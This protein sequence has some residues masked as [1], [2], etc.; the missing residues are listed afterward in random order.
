M[1]FA[2]SYKL[3]VKSSFFLRFTKFVLVGNFFFSIL[4]LF[5]NLFRWGELSSHF[6]VQYFG[7]AVFCLFGFC[8][9]QKWRWVIIAALCVA[10]NAFIIFPRFSLIAHAQT[11]KPDMRLV[12]SNVYH[13]NK[14][15]DGFLKLVGEENPDVLITQESSAGWRSALEALNNMYPYRTSALQADKDWILLFSKFPILENPENQK[16]NNFPPILATLQYKNQNFTLLSLH[17]STPKSGKGLSSRNLQFDT[18]AA[19]A[20]NISTPKIII[21]DF[22]SSTWSPYFSKLEKDTGLTSVRK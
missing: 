2:H 7:I 4:G 17:P 22:N 8:L 3:F 6:R 15:Y 11:S 19:V 21:G 20:K 18:L 10:L 12:L 9:I 1:R 5:G 13:D 14:N 16:Q